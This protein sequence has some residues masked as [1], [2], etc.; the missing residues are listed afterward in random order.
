MTGNLIKLAPQKRRKP[1]PTG[2]Y[3]RG[4]VIHGRARFKHLRNTASGSERFI[5][6]GTSNVKDAEAAFVRWKA[7]HAAMKGDCTD[8]LFED[9]CEIYKTHLERIKPTSAKRYLCSIAQLSKTLTGVRMVDINRPHLEAF[10][11]VREKEQGRDGKVSQSSIIR[12]LSCLGSIFSY[13]STAGTLIDHVCPVSGYLKANKVTL[14]NGPPGTRYLSV[15]EEEIV[16][17]TCARNI[18]LASNRHRQSNVTLYHAMRIAIDTGLRLNEQVTLTRDRVN[19]VRAEIFIPAD[20]AKN[21]KDRV[22]PIPE[23]SLAAMAE[24][25]SSPSCNYLFWHGTHT[26][27]PY[28]QFKK[29]FEALVAQVMLENPAFQYFS[30]HDLRRTCG[31]R[32]IQ[33]GVCSMLEVSIWLGHSSIKVTE[34][35]YAFLG[36]DALRSA[37]IRVDQARVNAAIG[38]GAYKAVGGFGIK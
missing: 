36:K 31:C 30:W 10:R 5:C 2:M 38:G 35:H 33:S 3:W 8:I 20:K 32:L 14:K 15:E 12:D 34:A 6:L 9:A 1:L 7:R 21:S 26:H 13:L 18:E 16:F 29:T 19:T 22:V 4:N 23:R 25:V 27:R 11:K 28:T 17:A 37:S 24:M